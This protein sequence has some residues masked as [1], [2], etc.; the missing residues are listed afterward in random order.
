MTA[1]ESSNVLLNFVY[2]NGDPVDFSQFNC[3][4]NI[5]VRLIPELA[6]A[7]E[8]KQIEIKILHNKKIKRKQRKKK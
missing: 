2:K 7:V 3:A 5:F 1:D 8:N 6:V 4:S